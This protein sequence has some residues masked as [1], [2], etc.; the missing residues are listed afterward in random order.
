MT[1][2]RCPG[3]QGKNVGKVGTGQFYCWDCCIEYTVSGRGCRLY[4]VLQDGELAR[5]AG[6]AGSEHAS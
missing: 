1:E 3:C 2:W 5:L 6:M 4:E